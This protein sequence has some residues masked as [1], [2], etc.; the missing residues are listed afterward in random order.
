M[1]S[2]LLIHT[3]RASLSFYPWWEDHSSLHKE[4]HEPTT[5]KVTTSYVVVAP[6]KAATDVK[7]AV[8]L[9]RA[10]TISHVQRRISPWLSG[11]KR[12]LKFTPLS[13]YASLFLAMLL[14]AFHR[15]MLFVRNATKWKTIRR[16]CCTCIVYSFLKIRNSFCKQNR[17]FINDCVIYNI[18]IER[19]IS[20]LNKNLTI[21]LMDEWKEVYRFYQ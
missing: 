9:S 12:L 4:Y 20:W 8:L 6:W 14:L 10:A 16:F 1:S 3:S 13:I 15:W 2:L 17:E 19:I 7:R 18:N 11:D 5:K 21:I